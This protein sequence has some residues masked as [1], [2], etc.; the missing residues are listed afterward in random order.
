[1]NKY[2]LIH[3]FSVPLLALLL[4]S[5]SLSAESYEASDKRIEIMGRHQVQETGAVT[6]GA[7][8]VTFHIKFRGSRLEAVIGD[9]FRDS[10]SYNWFTVKVDDRT[11]SRFRTRK[12]KRIY[13][14]ADSL[15]D[16]THTVVLSKATEGQNGRN[17]LVEVRTEELLQAN[18]LSGRKIEF[19]GN[20]ITS[21]YGLDSQAIPC[22]LGTWFDQ[23]HAWYAYGPRIARRMDAQWMLS[24]VSGMGM[25]R[26]WNSPGPVMPDVYKG[27]YMSYS[28]TT[29]NWDFDLYTPDL[30]VIAL[31]TN[32][33]SDGDGDKPRPELN[34]DAFVNEYTAFTSQ[35]RQNY[36]G[37][38]ILVMNSPGLDSTKNSELTTYL[39][40][41]IRNLNNKGEDEIYLFTFHDRYLEGC[42]GH[43][44]KKGHKVMADS[45]EPV[46][47]KIM[48]W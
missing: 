33:F 32:D 14:L 4:I 45:L 42:D 44:G 46:I 18:S 34:G 9:E 48:G 19:I 30:V 1:M 2:Q 43:P 25:Y 23:H 38:K 26:N 8:G 37:A 15:E 41:V 40:R 21:G 22:S 27:I 35:V 12:G 11:P 24:S 7:S 17:S 39:E 47:S 36:P 29:S 28:D 16:E 20:S 10:T 13:A 3:K 6:F 5:C 31:G